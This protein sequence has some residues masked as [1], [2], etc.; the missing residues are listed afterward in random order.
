MGARGPAPTPTVIRARTGNPQN[1]PMPGREPEFDP[2]TQRPDWWS[3]SVELKDAKTSRPEAVGK[4]AEEI[5][6]QLSCQLA[7]IGLLTVVDVHEFGRYCHM[8]AH[9]ILL[10]DFLDANGTV[11][12]TYSE[13][14]LWKMIQKEDG[15]WHR[16]QVIERTLSGFKTYPQARLYKEYSNAL[17]RM[18]DRF[19]LTPA[20]RSRLSVPASAGYFDGEV[21]PEDDF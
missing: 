7:R 5:Y 4:I 16:E 15:K 11:Y 3:R 10:R 20:M 14:R 8:M 18:S 21:E 19:G 17:A 12:P 2:T 1:R 9:W 6:E 13:N